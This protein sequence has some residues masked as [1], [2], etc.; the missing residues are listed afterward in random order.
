MNPPFGLKKPGSIGPPVHGVHVA[1]VNEQGTDEP[2]GTV[3]DIRV[4]GPGIMDGYW[5]DSA[6][7]RKTLHR[8]WVHTGDLGRFD[9]DGYL[10]FVGRRKDVIVGRGNKV[11]PLEVEATL[12]EHPAVRGCC[13]IGVP[14]A[15]CGEAPHAYVVL[16]T[17]T[18]A[19]PQDLQA[20]VGSR[21][22]EFMVTAAVGRRLSVP[23]G[24]PAC[25]GCQ[26]RSCGV[27]AEP[28]VAGPTPS[29]RTD[30]RF[31]LNGPGDA[32]SRT[33]MACLPDGRTHR[34]C[35]SSR[36]LPSVLRHAYSTRYPK[37]DTLCAW[38]GR[39]RRSSLIRQIHSMALQVTT[40][41]S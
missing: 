35:A 12:S 27:P 40:P 17:G 29:L 15:E 11:A 2:T 3:G 1:V 13:V 6:M 28:G 24:N 14:D 23:Q 30:R 34:G 7:T 16:Q 10:W 36:L 5:N 37:N 38:I 22:A 18:T 39:S 8:R 31:E 26:T 9:E 4:S 21:L 25:R 32:G 41:C 33:S 19:A 20:F